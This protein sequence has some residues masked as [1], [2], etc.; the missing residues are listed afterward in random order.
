MLATVSGTVPLQAAYDDCCAP[1]CYTCYD[2]C[3]ER[4]WG[5]AE[6]LYWKIQDSP[7]PTP[8]VIESP[9]SDAVIGDPDTHVVLG[10][11]K[12]KNDWVSGGRFALGYWF[13]ECRTF[14]AEASYFIL[15][16]QSKKHSVFGPGTEGS[17]YLA[18]PFFNTFTNAEDSTGI[19]G[20]YDDETGPYSGRAVL[21]LRNRMQGAELN[22]IMDWPTCDCNFKVGLL[23]G[24]RWWN[25]DETLSFDVESPYLDFPGNVFTTK[26]K[27]HTQNNFYGGQIGVGLDY[28]CG[29]FFANVKGKIAFGANCSESKICG[30]FYTNEYVD[31]FPPVLAETVTTYE[32]GIFAQGTNIG[33]CKKT[34]FAFLPEVNANIG[35]KITDCLSIKAGYTFLYVSKVLRPG[36]Q[37]DRNIN[38]TQSFAIEGPDAALS[39]DPS[40]R[41]LKKTNSIW[42]QGLS[43]GFDLIF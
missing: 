19:A 22:A 16:Y 2:S 32:G 33:S 31:S 36:S 28:F 38:P 17:G 20:F 43:V 26:D 5:S 42:A 35:Y 13:D 6:Y 10:S 29:C 39:G 23:A 27:F 24:F 37:I 41:A 11:K 7:Q 21:K 1:D 14:G 30:N 9:V 3:C 18:V 40:P 12:I 25:F 4:F 15:P 34:H 8:L